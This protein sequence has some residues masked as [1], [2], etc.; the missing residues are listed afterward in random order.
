MIALAEAV[1]AL[2]AIP[3]II[4]LFVGAGDRL[5]LDPLRSL[6][7][8]SPARGATHQEAPDEHSQE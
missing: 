6:G 5:G 8:V 2:V 3:L 7:A 4:S 1:C